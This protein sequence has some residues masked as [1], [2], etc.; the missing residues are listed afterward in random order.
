MLTDK[1]LASMEQPE[2]SKQKLRPVSQSM[3]FK[4]LLERIVRTSSKPSWARPAATRLFF[5]TEADLKLKDAS[6]RGPITDVIKTAS[7]TVVSSNENPFFIF[8]LL[9]FGQ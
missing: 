1:S 2:L 9:K 6:V 5:A 7:A 4:I 8:I 3:F